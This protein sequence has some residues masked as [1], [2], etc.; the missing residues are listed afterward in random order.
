MTKLKFDIITLFPN[1]FSSP[2]KT[3]LLGKAI[4]KGIIKVSIHDLRNF[5]IGR[6]K[7]VDDR[8]FGGGPGMVLRADVLEK[9]LNEIK[10]T[11]LEDSDIKPYVI[12][13]DPAGTTLTQGK[14][15]RFISKKWLLLICGHY[16]GVDERFKEL[17]V[18]EEV[19]IGDYILSGGEAAAIVLIESTSR[20][21]PGFL[22]KIQSVQFESFSKVTIGGN[23]LTLLDY[24]NYTK[25]RNFEG[26][27]VPPVL[28]SGN[29]EEIVKWRQ[30]KAVE[31]TKL[32]RPDLLN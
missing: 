14:V 29:H 3:S 13:F 31:K 1:F 17:Y 5:G 32:Q 22:G 10:S 7:S 9:S 20:L 2:L 24:P 30:K 19:S 15:N 8:P 12:L 21:I 18:D 26:K 6:H 25:P 16:E 28:L 4:E 27:A 23:K 11:P